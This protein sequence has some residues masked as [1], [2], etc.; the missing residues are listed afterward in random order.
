MSNYLCHFKISS[1]II[2]S[3]HTI[4]FLWAYVSK[5][6]CVDLSPIPA[7]VPDSNYRLLASQAPTLRFAFGYK[8][9][10]LCVEVFEQFGIFDFLPNRSVS[11]Q[12]V[13]VL[14]GT[15]FSILRLFSIPISIFNFLTSVNTEKSKKPIPYSIYI[16]IICISI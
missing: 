1:P 12:S 7:Q 13:P 5:S 15:S 3:W 16:Y 4:S 6:C 8:Y 9:K 10:L 14:F 2:M 11:V